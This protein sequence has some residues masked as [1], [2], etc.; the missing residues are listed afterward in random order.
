MRALV[1]AIVDAVALV[2]P[3]RAST[4]ASSLRGLTNSDAAPDVSTLAD[5]PAA[6]AASATKILAPSDIYLPHSK[7]RRSL[8]IRQGDGDS[9]E[10]STNG[11]GR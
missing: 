9:R 11:R 5:T 2:S 6:R 10:L 4:I 7:L 8:G 1:D 3:A